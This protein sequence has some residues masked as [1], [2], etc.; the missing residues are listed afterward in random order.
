MNFV[1][2]PMF[3]ASSALYPL[4]KMKE[5]SLWLYYI[6]L[7]NPFT[8]A[9]ELIRFAFYLEVNWQALGIVAGCTA[10]I[11]RAV[12]LGLRSVSRH[13]AAQGRRPG[14]VGGLSRWRNWRGSG[15]SGP[16]GSSRSPRDRARA[17]GTSIVS[18]AT[19]WVGRGASST[20]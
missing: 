9:V 14:H 20:S 1:I 10:A 15:A 2:F 3:F 13:P 12:V 18:I 6:C 16:R 17:C 11:P 19:T 8:W 5:G 7:Y 4:W